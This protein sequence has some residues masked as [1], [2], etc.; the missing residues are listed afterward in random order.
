[1]NVIH[2]LIAI[3][4]LSL[5]ACSASNEDLAFDNYLVSREA[6]RVGDRQLP[7]QRAHRLHEEGRVHTG[8]RALEIHQSRRTFSS[9]PSAALHLPTSPRWI[10]ETAIQ[11]R[12]VAITSSSPSVSN[13]VPAG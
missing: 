6:I 11:P 8:G 4:C 12:P 1:M 7:A 9:T 13:T 5:L 2:R 3:V 10:F